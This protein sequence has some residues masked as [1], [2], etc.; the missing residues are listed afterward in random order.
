MAPGGDLLTLSTLTAAPMANLMALGPDSQAQ[1]TYRYGVEVAAPL[2]QT[3]VS[4]RVL[5]EDVRNRLL[6][7]FEETS[8]EGLAVTTR[9]AGAV[10]TRGVGFTVTRRLGR[11]VAGSVTYTWGRSWRPDPSAPTDSEHTTAGGFHDVVARIETVFRWTGTRVAA[12]GRLNSIDPSI[13]NGLA[14]GSLGGFE[15][16]YDVHVA[17]RLPLL[18]SLTRADWEVLLSF[19]NLFY[20]EAAAGTLDELAVSNPQR[21]VLGGV[22]VRF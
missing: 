18:A 7:S 17:Q 19:R 14:P 22:S 10:F 11:S 13:V 1:R 21:R 4:A 16:R 6:T 5:Q 20:E 8:D 3:T 15:P 12:Y 9:N 2:G